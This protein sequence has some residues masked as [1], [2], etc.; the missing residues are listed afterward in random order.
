[1]SYER[2][3]IIL[4]IIVAIFGLLYRRIYKKR[5]QDS[6]TKY[7]IQHPNAIKV[8]LQK[9]SFPSNSVSILTLDDKRPEIFKGDKY[10]FYSSPG[11][12]IARVSYAERNRFPKSAKLEISVETNKSYFIGYSIKKKEFYFEEFQLNE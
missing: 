8:F 6:N 2:Q 1:M 12:H 10:G 9:E 7:L 11:T 3:R 5:L 4:L